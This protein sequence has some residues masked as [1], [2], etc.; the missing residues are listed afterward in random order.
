MGV[1]A[2]REAIYKLVLYCNLIHIRQATKHFPTRIC[3]FEGGLLRV[4]N[5]RQEDDRATYY[6]PSSNYKRITAAVES[7]NQMFTVS[8][9]VVLKQTFQVLLLF[10]FETV[11]ETKTYG[12]ATERR[13]CP[14]HFQ[15]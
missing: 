6:T 8:K 14:Y 9:A 10:K 12:R 5:T 2:G 11:R 4:K 13:L 7:E 1:I 15:K 3:V